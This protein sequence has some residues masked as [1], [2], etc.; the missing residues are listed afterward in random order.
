MRWKLKHNSRPDPGCTV[1]SPVT[2]VDGDQNQVETVPH[3][4]PVKTTEGT[5][6]RE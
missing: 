3:F 5:V 6:L 2:N 1:L 4:F